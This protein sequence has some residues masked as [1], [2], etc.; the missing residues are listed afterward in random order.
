[1]NT[2]VYFLKRFIKFN[3]LF[4]V[5][6]YILISF[7]IALYIINFQHREIKEKNQIREE[8]KNIFPNINEAFNK[9]KFF[10]NACLKNKLINNKIPKIINFSKTVEVSTIIP[11]YNSQNYISR[12]IKSIQNQNII[13]LEIMLVNDFSF[14]NTSYII[15]RLKKKDQRI[16]IINNKR[17]MGTLYSR[18]IGVLFS[19]GKYIFHLDS[20]DMFL[21]EDIFY[22]VINIAYKQNF[23]IIAFKV[24]SS[25]FSIN[26]TNSIWEN[27]FSNKYSNL[28]LYQPELGLYPMRPGKTLGSYDIYDSYLWNKCIESNVY[29]NTLNKIGS[30][31]YSRYMVLDEDRII[32]YALF[33]TAKSMKY[34]G[35]FGIL[36]SFHPNCITSKK[37]TKIEYLLYKLYFLDIVIDFSQETFAS[38]KLLIYLVT[39]LLQYKEFKEIIKM[40]KYNKKLFISC[41]NRIFNLKYISKEDKEEIKK[42]MRKLDFQNL[43]I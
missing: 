4:I 41:I 36:K 5:I 31:R 28:I 17:H 7:I 43:K 37:H 20:D 10:L 27:R 14:D 22:T 35:K 26:I 15:N 25:I 6:L 3:V 29:K 16:T 33:N 34:I 23:D 2:K 19:K 21:D 1:M 38:R 8:I 40:N 11:I 18:S 42:R 13:D 39:Y 12:A 30:K 9:G 32:I 24:I